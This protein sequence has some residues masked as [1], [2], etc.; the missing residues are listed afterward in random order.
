[1]IS[2]D[3]C[4]SEFEVVQQLCAE[5]LQTVMIFTPKIGPAVSQLSHNCVLQLF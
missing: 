5:P 2:G 4:F 1:M 3:F